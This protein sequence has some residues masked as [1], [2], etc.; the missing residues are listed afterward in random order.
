[1]VRWVGDNPERIKELVNILCQPD[2]HIAQR[3]AWVVGDLASLN[4]G[5]FHPHFS[6]LVPL[7]RKNVHDAVRRNVLRVFMA[8]PCPKRWQG[9]V[10]E[11]CFALL[12]DANQPVAV[13]VFAMDSIG[14]IC[15]D[16]PELKSE[17]REVI[18]RHW[19][20]ASAAFRKRGGKYL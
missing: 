15:N 1:M 18:L 11:A 19:E 12:E 3:A 7:L 2:Q 14:M 6:K 10:A 13:R 8:A 20:F 9:R 5:L 16:F 4:P 17:L